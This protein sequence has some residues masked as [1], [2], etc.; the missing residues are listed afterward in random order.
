MIFLHLMIFVWHCFL[1]ARIALG[2]DTSFIVE[3]LLIIERYQ[4]KLG[5]RDLA[6]VQINMCAATWQ[7]LYAV[8]QTESWQRMIHGSTW[9][10]RYISLGNINIVMCKAAVSGRQALVRVCIGQGI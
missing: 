1:Y 10:T 2:A 9:H 5:K 7:E 8:I 6:K 3:H 4:S